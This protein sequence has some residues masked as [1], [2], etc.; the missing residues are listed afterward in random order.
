MLFG[1]TIPGNLKLAKEWVS[2]DG[3][4]ALLLTVDHAP[5]AFTTTGVLVN[6]RHDAF[7]FRYIPNSGLCY[8]G[9]TRHTERLY[10]D[11]MQ[12]VCKDRHRPLSYEKTRRAIA[13]LKNLHFY[14]VGLKNTAINTQAESYRVLTGPKAERAVT[15][16][17]GRAFVQGH[18]FGSG[19]IGD[20]RETVGVS[21]G[22]RIWSNRRLSVADYLDWI[23]VLDARLGGVG[24][25]A[26]SQLDLVH[27]PK[28]LTK[29]PD[30]VI[31]ACWN[32]AAYRAAPR[33]RVCHASWDNY[34]ETQLTDIGLSSFK[35][36]PVTSELIF[37]IQTDTFS[38]P[39]RFSTDGGPLF[40]KLSTEW[41]LEVLTGT[42][43]WTE[44]ETWLSMNPPVFYASDRSSFQGMNMMQPPSTTGV[45]LGANDTSTLNWDGCAIRIEFES[46]KARGRA[47]VHQHLE[48]HLRKLDGLQVLIYD[49]RTGEA[50]D[51]ICVS[52]NEQDEC[53][54]SFYH[55]KGA[56]GKPSGTRVDDVYEVA[57][58]VIKSIGYCE[59]EVLIKHVEQRINAKRHKHP[60]QFYVGDME[61]F[62]ACLRDTPA[63][64][65]RFEIY[66]VQPGISRAA[67][68][69]HLADLM[70]FGIE[71]AH[72]GG[73]AKATWLIS[74]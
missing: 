68:D 72:R 38:V 26:Q 71:Y 65:L 50:A 31:A 16:G 25:I 2:D 59:M 10:Q 47:T 28:R 5:P 55:C 11:F 45:A 22:S 62:K 4:M 61:Q 19:V 48:S 1:P 15:A 40:S 49:H 32:K 44:M 54:V 9:S 23:D 70:A 20:K 21:S 58:Q 14:N 33:V 3:L 66:G 17:D 57:G 60:S 73:A 42:D 30:K 39:Y 13:G 56:G 6:V 37:E 18:F 35:S 7:V 64:K 43:D 27:H 41:Q 29:L 69:S 46:N 36:N 51:F 34:E 63:N 53:L 24:H 52:I 12:I 74:E 67:I 8:I